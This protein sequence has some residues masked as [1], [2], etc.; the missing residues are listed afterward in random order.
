VDGPAES[1]SLVTVPVVFTGRRLELNA[2]ATKPEAQI[3]VEFLD[4]AGNPDKAWG[5]SDPVTGDSLRQ[6]VTWKGVTD[7]ASFAGKPVSL[8]FTLRSA[9]LFSFAFRAD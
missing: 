6:S 8:R 4:A 5:I 1:G 2:V 3:T 9:S 7:V